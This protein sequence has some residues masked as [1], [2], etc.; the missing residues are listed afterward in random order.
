MGRWEPN[1]RGRLAQAVADAPP[2]ATAM[3]TVGAM[4]KV[5]GAL[6]EKSPELAR[7]RHGIVSPWT[8]SWR[9]P[10]HTCASEGAGGG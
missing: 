6:V 7:L 5:A 1:A 10:R 2:S 4:L 9:R 3:G 8:L